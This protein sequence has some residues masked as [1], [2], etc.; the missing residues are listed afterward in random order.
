MLQTEAHLPFVSFFL[1][2]SVFKLGYIAIFISS[3]FPRGGNFI[4]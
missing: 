4:A 1:A 3:I 2:I